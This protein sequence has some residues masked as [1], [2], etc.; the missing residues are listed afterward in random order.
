MT[1]QKLSR[2]LRKPTVAVVVIA[3]LGIG[4][5]TAVPSVRER[6]A[7]NFDS[8]ANLFLFDDEPG[9]GD[10]QAGKKDNAFKRVFGAPFR[11][12]SRM[13]KRKD[14]GLAMK[15][16][17]EKEIEKMKVIPISRTRNSTPDQIADAGD[18]TTTEAT[19]AE[20]AAQ[21]LFEEAVNLHDNGRLDGALEKLVAATVLQSNFSEA[22]NLLGVCYDERGQYKAAQEEYKKALKIESNN[23]RFLNNA[24]YSYYLAGDFGNS[25]KH[26][27]RGLKIT[28]NDR[29]MH[30]NIGLAY[31]RKGDYD[32]AKQHFTIA[33]GEVGASLN[34][35][36]IY[37][38]QGKYDEAAK[39][40]ETALQM[41][42]DS[43]PAMSNLAQLYDRAGRVREAA[44]LHEQYKKLS[45]S[46]KEK[47]QVADKNQQ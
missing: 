12:M 31:G 42:P 17:T 8:G 32:K 40:Y 37:S 16:P 15:K 46:E 20:L 43:L 10:A 44:L 29:R 39:Y 27:N 2:I 6:L 45:A 9:T 1:L 22:Y 13:F 21:T 4:T 26:Y 14:D 3:A 36:Y 28:P 19:T 34:L 47:D 18:G 24:G 41:K 5:V 38:Q 7:A 30:N 33:V 35:G 25:I 11:L 23:A